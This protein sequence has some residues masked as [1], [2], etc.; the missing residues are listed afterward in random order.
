MN[1]SAGILM[2]RKSEKGIEVFLVHPGGPYFKNKDTD[3]W[4]IPKGEF[5]EGKEEPFDAA[6]RELKEE[7]GFEVE[8]PFITLTPHP[9]KSG[10]LVHAFACEKNVDPA[11]LKSNTIIIEWPPKTGRKIEIPEVDRG[12]WFDLETAKTKIKSA[13]IPFLDELQKH[14]TV[15]M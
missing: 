11:T 13:Q 15:D 14:L 5:E 12:A 6:L 8:G 9:L 4:S 1:P 3:T 2:Y 7:T 10:R